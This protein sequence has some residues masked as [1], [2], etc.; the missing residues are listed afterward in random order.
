MSTLPAGMPGIVLSVQSGL[1]T[2]SQERFGT[3]FLIWYGPT[4]G[5]GEFDRLLIFVPVGTKPADGNASRFGNA[6]YAVV[7][8]I[9]ILPD[10][11]SVLMPEMSFDLPLSNAAAPLM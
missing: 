9:V 5:G 4:P 3:T 1:R 6:P 7:S 8:W 11:S 2:T 10:A